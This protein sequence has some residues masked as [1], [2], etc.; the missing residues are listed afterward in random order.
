MAKASAKRALEEDLA[1]ILQEGVGWVV[2]RVIEREEFSLWVRR[3]KAE[4]MAASIESGKQVV[5]KYLA[6]RNF[7][8]MELGATT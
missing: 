4:C 2:T 7:N 6:T 1:W 8:L 5:R 3:L